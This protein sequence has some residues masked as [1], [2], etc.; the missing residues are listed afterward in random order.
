MNL[1][2][3][4]YAVEVARTRSI[5]MAAEN[6][7]MNQPNLSRAIKEQTANFLRLALS[8]TDFLQHLFPLNA[9]I[10]PVCFRFFAKNRY[11]RTKYEHFPSKGKCI[12]N[13]VFSEFKKPSPYK[14][15][16]FHKDILCLRLIPQNTRVLR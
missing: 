7:Y 10:S 15:Y 14:N 13:M 1:L 5:T 8:D 9:H 3:L 4:K 16:I 11:I 12:R 6:L 2:H